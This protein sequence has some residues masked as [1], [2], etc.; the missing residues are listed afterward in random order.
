MRN[1]RLQYLFARYIQDTCTPAEKRELAA[2]AL[3]SKYEN[4]VRE[5]LEEY[6]DKVAEEI[7]LPEERA[8][9]IVRDILGQRPEETSF[10]RRATRSIVWRKIAV[11]ASVLLVLG[12]GSYFMFF[13]NGGKSGAIVQ[14]SE[15]PAGIHPPVTNRAMITLSNGQRIYLD[16]AGNG[17]FA[18]EENVKLVKLDNGRIAY[19]AAA[20]EA[21][22]QMKYNTL[23]NP[24][25][26]R[27]ID[28]KFSD[29]SHV[30]LNAGSSVTYPV[31]FIRNERNVSVS[32][33]AYFEVTHDAAKPFYVRKGAM[34]VQVLGTRFNVNAYDDE[35]EIKVTLLEGSVK[36]SNENSGGVLKPG[37]QA[38]IGNT[39][40]IANDVNLEEVMAW[41]NGLFQFGGA[42]I[43]EV[44]RQ[45]ARWYDVTV[46]YEDKPAKQHFRGEISRD[47][48]A[49]KVFKM[50]ETT[51]VVHFRTEGKKVFVGR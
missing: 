48:E 47:V 24:V 43:E 31:V 15:L 35:A 50:L 16:S 4:D 44:M 36:V 46:I 22:T 27:V 19:E 6:W 39:I 13:K 21:L 32:G 51:G 17:Q 7:R 42:G 8:T 10:G 26:S 11:A 34:Q 49:S 14:G 33:E 9:F 37:Q 45:I 38:S 30:W 23:E 28:M 20:G 29:G 25:G 2:L 12:L 40:K 18:E 5:L 3:A 1:A 41:K